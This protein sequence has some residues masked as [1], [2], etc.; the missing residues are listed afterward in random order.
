MLF[1]YLPLENAKDAATDPATADL[2]GR[3]L[4]CLGNF[5]GMNKSHPSIK[6]AVKWLFDHQLDNGSWYGRWEF[7]IFTERGPLLQDSVL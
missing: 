3:V 7:A 6:A 1:T 2:T 5:A 4:E